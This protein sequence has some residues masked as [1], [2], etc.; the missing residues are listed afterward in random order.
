MRIVF[1]GPPGVGKGT[2]ASRL[3]KYL[4]ILHLST[5]EMLRRAVAE[6]TEIGQVSQQYLAAGRLVPD[7]L[8]MALV[9][10]RLVRTD[11]EKG[12][13]LDGFPRTLVQAQAL[14]GLLARRGT[15]LSAVIELQVDDDEL[16]RRLLSRGRED[17]RPEVIRE[18]LVQ[19]NRQTA[20]LADYYKQRGLHYGIEGMGT[21][22]EVFRRIQTLVDTIAQSDA[23]R[24]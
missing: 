7:S 6:G 13:L 9:N 19:Y 14:D 1:M 22:D 10:E 12:Y 20:P 23:H 8:M 15:P 18:R 4:G 3:V 16:M 11:C 24:V 17:D 5:G 2:Q 21:P